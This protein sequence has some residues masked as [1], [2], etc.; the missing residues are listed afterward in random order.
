MDYRQL[1]EATLPDQQPLPL[2][3]NMLENRSRHNI[4]SI[5]ELSRGFNQNLL[6]PES[7]AKTAMNSGGKRYQWRG[8]A[9]FQRAMDN[10]LQGLDCADIYIDGIIIGSFA[11]AEEELLANHDCDVCAK[12]DRLQR[13]DLVASVTKTDFF[14]RSVDF[15]GHGGKWHKPARARENV[16]T[17]ELEKNG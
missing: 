11:D 17:C 8:P 6:H 12:L 5:V 3:E 14:V 7:R 1:N 2:I 16:G 15:F 13:E 10:L 9:I 4:F